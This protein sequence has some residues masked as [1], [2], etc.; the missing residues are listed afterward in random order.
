MR[1]L[2]AYFILGICRFLV[3]FLLFGFVVRH[4]YQVMQVHCSDEA[5]CS[6]RYEQHTYSYIAAGD[7]PDV[8]VG[9]HGNR[10]A[11]ALKDFHHAEDLGDQLL[12]GDQLVDQRPLQSGKQRMTETDNQD[13][14]D[15]EPLT[16]NMD[17]AIHQKQQMRRTYEGHCKC[18]EFLEMLF[19]RIC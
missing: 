8:P 16:A 3:A 18:Q 11:T 12:V 14:L 6:T 15:Y 10:N 17:V 9:I 2:F 4:L 19:T 5:N 7:L 1:V 13:W